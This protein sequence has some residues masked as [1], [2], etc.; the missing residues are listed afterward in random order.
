MVGE[1]LRRSSLALDEMTTKCAE[2]EGMLTRIV[3]PKEARVRVEALL[4]DQHEAVRI[5]ACRAVS[6]FPEDAELVQ[7]LKTRIAEDESEHVRYEA[8]RS[9]GP[10]VREGDFERAL[11]EAEQRPELLALYDDVVAY[12]KDTLRDP[13]C[14]PPEKYGAVE[15]LGAL[16]AEDW[17]APFIGSLW[18]A[19]EE[20]S[21]LAAL[22]AI[23]AS[24]DLRWQGIVKEAL[25]EDSEVLQ[26]HALQAA[27]AMGLTAVEDWVCRRAQR[28]GK[29][30]RK[31]ALKA[32]SGLDTKRARRVLKR[33][34]QNEKDK[35][36]F[37]ARSRIDE[38]A[39]V[40]Q[41]L[42]KSQGSE[43]KLKDDKDLE[44]SGEKA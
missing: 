30:M 29:R 37:E 35:L 43:S 15:A 41:M 21:K 32:L 34:A 24:A 20:K 13:K 2:L 6:L 9:F 26:R 18:Y 3:D 23:T 4:E 11:P 5:L 10:V 31:A 8:L 42:K 7:R 27:G 17:V 36:C 25:T 40:Q 33:V 44:N 39:F 19:A 38:A 16:S 14:C 1:G 12:L 28:G 22:M